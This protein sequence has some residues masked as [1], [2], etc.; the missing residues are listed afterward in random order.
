MEK[1]DEANR[2]V[3]RSSEKISRG[4]EGKGNEKNHNPLPLMA[5]PDV[6]CV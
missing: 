4:K 2:E 5:L 6:A 3:V 1:K